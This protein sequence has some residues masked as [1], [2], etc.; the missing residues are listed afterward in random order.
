[1][2]KPTLPAP[3]Y[4]IWQA[5]SAALALATRALEET[6]ALSREPGPKGD[7]GVPGN[8]SPTDLSVEL[9]RDRTV[10]I[11]Y[12]RGDSIIEIGRMTVPFPIYRGAFHHGKKYERGDM[13]TRN[14]SVWHCNEPTTEPPGSDTNNTNRAWQL[15]ARK[16]AN[17]KDGKDLMP[18]RSTTPF[19]DK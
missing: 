11:K 1:M 10:V 12:G 6:R 16:G 8:F 15:A 9:D 4:S 5:V 14:D 3:R 17:G 18:P 2:T 7:P 13:I 19:G